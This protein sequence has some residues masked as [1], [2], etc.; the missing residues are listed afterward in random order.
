MTERE[1]VA[2]LKSGEISGLESLVRLYQVRA[3][4]AAYV[5]VQ[6]RAAA[7]D[8]VQTA[9][10]TAYERIGQFDASRPFGPWFLRSVVNLAIKAARQRQRLVT[11][12][13]N[14][15]AQNHVLLA[16]DLT[17]TAETRE[18]VWLALQQLSPEQR[19]AIILHYYLDLSEAEIAHE[20]A[21]PHGT[22]KWRLHMARR[23]LRLL[24][25][26]I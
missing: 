14:D 26:L 15:A 1:A 20:M 3:I 12:D 6:D 7:E 19:A 4:R 24:L 5:I 16:P 9:F 8:I 18:A 11:L 25:R 2:L 22:I 13:E 23:K 17:D 10:L 21:A